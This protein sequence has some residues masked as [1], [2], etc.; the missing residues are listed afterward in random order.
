MLVTW[1][2]FEPGTSQIQVRR[3][4]M[5]SQFPDHCTI[6]QF[7]S[8]HDVKIVLNCKEFLL[9]LFITFSVMYCRAFVW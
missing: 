8:Q 9:L 3:V 2:R 1:L 6:V 5:W 7:V 4:A